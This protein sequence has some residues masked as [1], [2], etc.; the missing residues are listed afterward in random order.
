MGLSLDD[1]ISFLL[2]EIGLS[3]EAGAFGE[4]LYSF[5]SFVLRD[6]WPITEACL[7]HS[8]LNLTF[9]NPIVFPGSCG[10]C[11]SNATK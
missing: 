3:G 2:E 9:N 11:R 5:H 7:L 6:S 4:R 10:A 8:I 1:L